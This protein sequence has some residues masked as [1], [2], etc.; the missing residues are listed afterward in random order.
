LEIVRVHKI[1][2]F[3]D[4]P[5]EIRNSVLEMDFREPLPNENWHGLRCTPES[6][7]VAGIDLERMIEE[8]VLFR[9]PNFEYDEMELSFH[10]TPEEVR[11]HFTTEK[12]E[13]A[14]K[15]YDGDACRIVGLI[16]LSPNPPK[17]CGTSFFDDD[18]DKVAEVENEYNTMIMYPAD[19][20]HGPTNPFGD[21]KENSRLTIVFFLK[22]Y[23]KAW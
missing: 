13:D 12:F 21:T 22:K 3:F 14:S 5:N 11:G 7:V 6:K 16:Y 9:L 18:G 4:N 2:D 19:I 8:E 23:N 20:L 10:I 17:N 1:N 15:H